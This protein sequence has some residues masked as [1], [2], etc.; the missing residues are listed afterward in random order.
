[1]L[2]PS[3]P[4]WGRLQRQARRAFIALGGEALTGELAEWAWPRRLL[5]ERQPIEYRHRKSTARAARSI[6]AVRV[7]RVGREWLWMLP[8][9][10]GSEATVTTG[11]GGDG[12]GQPRSRNRGRG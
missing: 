5:L 7:R 9:A 8:T 1:L 11:D 2:L 4:R 6:G 3:R 12:D 10:G